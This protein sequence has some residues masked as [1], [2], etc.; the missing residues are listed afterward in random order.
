ML[1]YEA[2]AGAVALLASPDARWVTGHVLVAD[3]GLSCL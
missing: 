1:S 2:I 3:G